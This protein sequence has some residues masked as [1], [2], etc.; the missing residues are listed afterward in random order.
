MT[1]VLLLRGVNVGGKGKLPMATLREALQAA[2][3]EAPETYVQSGNAVFDGQVDPDTLAGELDRRAGVRPAAILVEGREF[4]GI[5]NENPFV[6]AESDPK[7][8]HVFVLT[9]APDCDQAALDAECA[10]DERV[11]LKDRHLYLHAPRYLTGSRIA[12]RLDRL[13]GGAP[14][15]RN[16]RTVENLSRMVERRL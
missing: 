6:E 15:G 9:A 7:A 12:P 2:G 13:L 14:T 4:L 11:V 16:W 1:T 3:A 10:S 5:R 8:L